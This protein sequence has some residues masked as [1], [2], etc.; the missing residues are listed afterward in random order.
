MEMRWIEARACTGAKARKRRRTGPPPQLKKPRSFPITCLNK[1]DLWGT[2]GV[3]KDAN[4]P[5]SRRS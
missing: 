4:H 5:I 2:Q 1:G 3:G